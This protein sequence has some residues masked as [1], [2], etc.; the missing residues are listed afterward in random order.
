MI[1]VTVSL[2]LLGAWLRGPSLTPLFSWP[3]PVMPANYPRFSWL[4]A[5]LAVAPIAGLMASW[6]SAWKG[7]TAGSERRRIPRAMPAWGWMAIGWT[8]AWWLLAWTRFRWFSPLQL[9]TFFPLW[10]GFVVG[11]NA[12]TWRRAGTCLMLRDSKAWLRLFIASAAFWW[13]F[14][15]LNRFGRNWR[16]LNAEAF[17]PLGYAVHATLCFS[18]VLPAVTAVRE[19]LGT[20]L[21]LQVNFAQGPRWHWLTSR[22]TGWWLIAGGLAGLVL[23]G[24][25]PQEFYP[26]IW[27]GPLAAAWG[28][29]ILSNRPS[30]TGEIA[31][32]DWRRAAS[33]MLAAT[34]CGI[35]WEMWNFHSVAKW[36]Y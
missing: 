30:V 8:L 19:L 14:E 12:L 36:V 6:A 5:A 28:M 34:I 25:W 26:A 21:S 23:I 29:G 24:S 16:Y 18:T 33:W 3:P 9:Y 27:I 32:G 2:P 22:R 35:F 4:A 20:Y 31:T 15:W 17:G 1:A 11:A 7:P 13:V 10:L